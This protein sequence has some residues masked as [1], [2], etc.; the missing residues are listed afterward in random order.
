LKSALFRSGS[1]SR[2]RFYWLACLLLC[3]LFGHAQTQVDI[4]RQ[5][6]GV[7][8]LNRGGT[9]QASWVGG[10]CVQVAPDG[11]KLEVAPAAC[12]SGTGPAG[13][14]VRWVVGST[15]GGS[16]LTEGTSD[17]SSSKP[18]KAELR[19]QGGAVFNVKAYGAK[20]DNVTDDTQA[21][22]DAIDACP[23]GGVVFFPAGSYRITAP[24]SIVN[25]AVALVGAHHRF[26]ALMPTGSSA[27]AINSDYAVRVAHLT[28]YAGTG[29]ASGALISVTG[30]G[31]W[32]NV[33]S[34]FEDLVIRG[35]YNGIHLVKA[36][37]TIVS[38][39]RFN[40]WNNAAIL[41]EHDD[42]D[43]GY[44]TVR[45]CRF[46]W[47]HNTTSSYG[48]YVRDAVGV[49]ITGNDFWGVALPIYYYRN[50]TV[51]SYMFEITSNTMDI[52]RNGG[53][54]VEHTGTG[55]V[56]SGT[57]A[58]NRIYGND[59]VEN[60]SAIQVSGSVY[61]W[62]I[63]N[64]SIHCP[65]T[66]NAYGIRVEGLGLVTITGNVTIACSTPIMEN[67]STA[68][69]V[70]ASGNLMMWGGSPTATG[71]LLLSDATLNYASLSGLAAANGS[72]VYCS[73][74]TAAAPCASGGT[75]A[76]ARRINGAWVCSEGGGGGGG[77]SGSGTAGRLPVWTS[78]SS[79]GD[80]AVSEGTS[81]VSSTKPIKA[82]LR[83]QGGAVFNVKAFGA[84]G[85]GATDDRTAIQAALNAA[86]A[87][88]GTVYVPAGIY[89][90]SGPLSITGRVRITGDNNRT[91]I[92]S[93]QSTTTGILSIDTFDA[94]I[95]DNVQ[96][97]SPT[98]STAGALI[99]ITGPLTY[100]N[101]G[102]RITNCLF[103]GGY[104]QINVDAAIFLTI[105]G[106]R[107]AGAARYPIRVNNSYN[108][109]Y[110]G[111]MITRNWLNGLTGVGIHIDNISG[112]M[113]TGNH[114]LTGT[115]PIEMTYTSNETVYGLLIA[116][117]IMDIFSTSGIKLTQS[118][119]GGF[120]N[121]TI[122]NNQ[123]TPISGS[124]RKMV[125]IS[126]N[127]TGIIQGNEVWCTFGES[128]EVGI[129]VDTTYGVWSVSGN[130]V[131][132]C[133]NAISVTPTSELV[134][135]SNN[136]FYWIGSAP[137]VGNA[138]TRVTEENLTYAQLG[139]WADGSLV[140]CTD[141]T[142]AAT[143]ASGGTGAFARRVNGAWVCF[144]EHSHTLAGDVTGDVGSTTV[145]R[146]QGRNVSNAA[147]S[148]GQALVWNAS[149][150]QWKP[151][152]VSGGG[153]S[154][155]PLDDTVLW[156]R[157]DFPNI[158]TSTHQI[159][160]YGWGANCSGPI[161]LVSK[162]GS[163]PFKKAYRMETGTTSSNICQITLG[164][165]GSS[166]TVLGALGSYGSWD[167]IFSFR[168]NSVA[169]TGMGLFVG[170]IVGGSNVPGAGASTAR[171][172]V[173]YDTSRGDTDF[174]F[175]ACNGTNCTRQSSGVS[176]DTAWHKLRI[177]SQTAGTILFSLDGGT[178]VSIDT[179]V[180]TG[181]LAPM[182]GVRTA[183]SA[184]KRVE[185]DRWYWS[186]PNAQ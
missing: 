25:K 85:G 34:T 90:V 77:V 13:S 95:I 97:T 119:S 28:I 71:K 135:V 47:P 75:G 52:V 18:I 166:A 104:D 65:W 9:G 63:S 136:R 50:V 51:D 186:G 163:S 14:L 74:C 121:V 73:D 159:G 45:D 38:R 131:R 93:T 134:S 157:E 176:F 83:D 138:R 184:A 94:V 141:C 64:N 168:N 44:L 156:F 111:I 72:I 127:F 151:T 113:I 21:I 182:F 179:N 84:V 146:I 36:I 165:T 12:M 54:V 22:Q 116:D 170:Y 105:E 169:S 46:A 4:N 130:T 35:G 70:V 19:D 61:D 59:L 91:S 125:D 174:M 88:G 183:E 58:N 122:V 126:G 78:P 149:E 120:G 49:R 161:S 164:S 92:L 7:L 158:G 5:T 173:E 162:T 53:I 172:G 160:T 40:E 152:T 107:F 67:V 137:F 102:S 129:S 115:I 8:Q 87:V 101:I 48:I 24:L 37:R 30:P 82:E 181:A 66:R 3:A 11:S 139:E 114:F 29:Q 140:Y 68:S 76:I 103:Y 81:E 26:T 123:I 106:N 145:A 27:I 118:G 133:A 180:P 60:S 108:A 155:N 31:H 177:R 16:S 167:S 62:T 112:V 56:W 171:I 2:Q 109:D 154:F 178:E 17:V 110:A 1:G 6:R 86:Q 10:R 98:N 42:P 15:L 57:I 23:N 185:T 33:N 55:Y 143:C 150:S 117:N 142:V 132:A 124:N 89:V 80:S 99:S 41:A 147:P 32:G 153:G 96:F 100:G 43:T 128:G 39:A 175:V 148:D 79:L 69:S 20:G 144:D